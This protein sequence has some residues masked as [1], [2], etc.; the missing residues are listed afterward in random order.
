M[1]SEFEI[2]CLPTGIGTMPHTNPIEACSLI[3]KYNANI[4]FWPQLSCRSYLE[5]M[6][7]QYSEGF[8]G[9]VIEEDKKRIWIDNTQSLDKQ[10]EQLY[11]RYLDNKFANYDVSAR[12]AAGLYELLSRGIRAQAVKGQIIGPVTMGLALLD[13]DERA[14]I[15]DDVL[16]DA[17]ARHLRLKAA[18]QEMKLHTISPHTIIFLD[19][20]YMVSF[21]SA[22]FAASREKV[23]NMVNEVFGGIIGLKGIHC[24]GNTDWSVILAT[25]LDILSFDT[26]NYAESL[27]LYP[28]DVNTFLNRGGIIAWGIVP[29][30]EE[31]I[32]KESPSSLQDR[33]GE[34]VAPF[35]RNGFPFRQILEQSLLTPSCGLEGLTLE[36]AS[37]VLELLAK[38]SIQIR[39]RYIS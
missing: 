7:V 28:T 20:P 24:C 30:R 1:S 2:G 22:F 38:L 17:L 26:Y 23:I 3:L 29:N 16:S 33:L 4:P 19:E 36:A 13:K 37:Q 25:K 10:L 21:G 31:D 27:T 8:P 34:A 12:Y 35:T 9:V 5:N 15:Y 39:K 18:W 6:Y 32:L 14:I 11:A